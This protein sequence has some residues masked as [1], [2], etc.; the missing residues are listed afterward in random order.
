MQGQFK[1]PSRSTG[2]W[3]NSSSTSSPGLNRAASASVLD[4]SLPVSAAAEVPTASTFE[5]LSLLAAADGREL[6][7]HNVLVKEVSDLCDRFCAEMQRSAKRRGQLNELLRAAQEEAR[8]SSPSNEV[9]PAWDEIE[10]SSEDDGPEW[11]AHDLLKNFA[12]RAVARGR[13]PARLCSIDHYEDNLPSTSRTAGM[14]SMREGEADGVAAPKQGTGR[15]SLSTRSGS[16]RET[17]PT[18]DSS[19]R[20]PTGVTAPTPPRVLLGQHDEQ[21]P[22]MSIHRAVRAQYPP[23]ISPGERHRLLNSLRQLPLR[24]LSGAAEGG[25]PVV[26]SFRFDPHAGSNDNSPRAMTS[27]DSDGHDEV[28]FGNSRASPPNSL[29]FP[30]FAKFPLE[31][32]AQPKQQRLARASSSKASP[33]RTLVGTG[34]PTEAK[35]PVVAPKPKL[36]VSKSTPSMGRSAS[37][38]SVV[39][40]K[41][42]ALASSLAAK[43][44]KVTSE[45]VS[46]TTFKARPKSAPRNAVPARAGNRPA[47]SGTVRPMQVSAAAPKASLGESTADASDATLKD[48]LIGRFGSSSAGLEALFAAENAPKET[49]RLPDFSRALR[50]LGYPCVNDAPAMFRHAA[51]RSGRSAL[52]LEDFTHV[53]SED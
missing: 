4:V 31:Q 38:K 10:V 41:N 23:S 44:E 40:S 24:P 30:G 27:A 43:S 3:A 35:P 39:P 1:S 19:A 32:K 18:G 29:S 17:S 7:V 11:N 45:G 13:N 12:A 51:G 25:T 50:I 2:D 20:T 48:W 14:Q 49:L 5:V 26:D 36:T 53:L 47:Y 52:S 46:A 37:S 6:E 42:I 28:C 34:Q 16:P 9:S 8:G 33:K 22:S 21:L 15:T